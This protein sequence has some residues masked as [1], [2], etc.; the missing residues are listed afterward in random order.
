MLNEG[1][2]HGTVDLYF[3]LIFITER[4]RAFMDTNSLRPER[5]VAKS[6]ESVWPKRGCAGLL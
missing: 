1:V 2:Y 5:L 6:M 4:L 3:T